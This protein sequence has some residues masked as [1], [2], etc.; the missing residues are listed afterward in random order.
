[1][2]PRLTSWS[3]FQQN[4]ARRVNYVGPEQTP[5]HIR[6]ERGVDLTFTIHRF[7]S[8]ID[9]VQLPDNCPKCFCFAEIVKQR[10]RRTGVCECVFAERLTSG[11]RFVSVR[12]LMKIQ[13][14]NKTISRALVDKWL[15]LLFGITS[16]RAILLLPL[17]HAWFVV[18]SGN[19]S[20]ST[21]CFFKALIKSILVH[22]ISTF[23]C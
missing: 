20:S 22:L 11:S 2:H 6:P 1:M 18:N 19:A 10:E 8:G 13:R 5:S 3:H 14:Q 7:I 15:C 23:L 21:L 4:K 16:F 12:H 9:F 17:N